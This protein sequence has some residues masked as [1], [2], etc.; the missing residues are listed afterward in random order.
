MRNGI[1]LHI[2]KKN[3][4]QNWL[5]QISNCTVAQSECSQWFQ[6]DTIKG[7]E[8]KHTSP[9]WVTNA[10]LMGST[11]L[12][13]SLGR[14]AMWICYLLFS[15]RHLLPVG[16][17]RLYVRLSTISHWT[18]K[19]TEQTRIFLHPFP[20]PSQLF[21]WSLPTLFPFISH[22][23]TIKMTNGS[24][25]LNPVVTSGGSESICKIICNATQIS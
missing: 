17:G 18:S 7:V 16:T 19:T 20:L 9:P 25:E 5:I 10:W 12:Q 23:Q 11:N 14:Q 3:C 24:Q 13:T 2:Y 15:C 1:L 6:H 22:L 21:L 4:T 8:Y